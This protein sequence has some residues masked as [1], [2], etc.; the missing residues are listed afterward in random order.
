MEKSARNRK[1]QRD[2]IPKSF[3]SFDEAAEFWDTHSVTDYLDQIKEVPDVE[4]DIVRRHF[5]VDQ[6]LAHRIH[7]IAHRCGVLPEALVNSWL[8]EK[9]SRIQLKD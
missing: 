6:E 3:K 4:I 5:R 9:A 7:R 8:Q 1:K 2:A